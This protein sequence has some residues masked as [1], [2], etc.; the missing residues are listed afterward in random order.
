MKKIVL[1]LFALTMTFASIA[2]STDTKGNTQQEHRRG[3]KH[4]GAG[5][6]EKL[7]LTDAQKSEVKLLNDS[8]RKQMQDLRNQGSITVD[9]QKEK[10]Q[11]LS[12]EHR[13]KLNAILTPEQRQQAEAFKKDFKGK[14][15][16]FSGVRGNR[17]DGKGERKDRFTN[18]TKDLNL[19]A[20]QSTKMA[21][22]NADFK[23]NIK[24]LQQNTSLTKE[25]K[26]E[27]MK[28]LMQKHRTELKDLLTADQKK[29]LKNRMKNRATRSAV[30]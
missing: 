7:N 5:Y 6:Y 21:S 2:Q 18:L 16:D 26:K 10:R 11:A 12:K 29:D 3:G 30:K 28:S 4:D 27:Q 25:D 13:E 20:D 14:K 22:L 8:Y 15:G 1:G 24:S 23:N 9:Q 19:S 17:K